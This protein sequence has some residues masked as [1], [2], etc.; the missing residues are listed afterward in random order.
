[1]TRGRISE[2][3]MCEAV[4][5]TGRRCRNAA[6]H[7]WRGEHRCRWH[8][9]PQLRA[10]AL[11]NHPRYRWT[12]DRLER[13]CELTERGFSDEQIARQ[14][15]TTFNAIHETRERHNLPRRRALV[16][17]SSDVARLLGK[18]CQKSVIRWIEQG[19]L[20]GK[21]GFRQGPH[22]V[23]LVTW[24]SLEAFVR[25]ERYWPAWDPERVTNRQLLRVANRPP[26]RY[27]THAEV[28]Q[29]CGV[30]IQ[31]VNTWIRKGWLRATRYGNWH[32][33]EDWLDE[34]RRHWSYGDGYRKDVAA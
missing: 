18:K 9:D 19:W 32:V 14:M 26:L 20:R 31:T 23:W 6:S 24:Q 17:T 1:M 13:I 29:T 27:L 15:G 22:K 5:P 8:G 3:V 28:A 12:P 4:L 16:L 21:R 10:R 34:F 25:D 11:R 33:R 30:E 7:V 2:D